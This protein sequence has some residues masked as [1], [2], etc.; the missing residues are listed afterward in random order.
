MAET[1]AYEYSVLKR[2]C[3]SCHPHTYLGLFLLLMIH[4]HHQGMESCPQ[5]PTRELCFCL[6]VCLFVCLQ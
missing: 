6:F 5:I 1:I 2:P 4:N 3:P